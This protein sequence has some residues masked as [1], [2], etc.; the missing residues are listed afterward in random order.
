MAELPLLYWALPAFSGQGLMILTIAESPEFVLLDTISFSS[1]CCCIARACCWTL[2]C[3]NICCWD[4]WCWL[5]C[6]CC[7]STINLHQCSGAILAEGPSHRT[8]AEPVSVSGPCIRHRA[9][10]PALPH[11]CS[12]P[13]LSLGLAIVSFSLWSLVLYPSR[14]GQSQISRQEFSSLPLSFFESNYL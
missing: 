4:C 5:A 3:C 2:H 8:G 9:S 7:H 6:C 11:S 12:W 14:S 10:S 13:T 1:C